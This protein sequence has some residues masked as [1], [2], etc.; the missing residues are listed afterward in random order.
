MVSS[1]CRRHSP[2]EE[3]AS[4]FSNVSGTSSHREEGGTGPS[5]LSAWCVCSHAAETEGVS[6]EYCCCR[7]VLTLKSSPW[8][9]PW[10]ETL[11]RCYWMQVR[12]ENTPNRSW[13]VDTRQY[14]D[15][16]H[17]KPA[18]TP[19]YASQKNHTPVDTQNTGKI[20][21]TSTCYAGLICVRPKMFFGVRVTRFRTMHL[22]TPPTQH[23]LRISLFSRRLRQ[24]IPKTFSH[25]SS[26]QTSLSRP[27]LLYI[28]VS[29]SFALIGLQYDR[30][31]LWSIRQTMSMFFACEIPIRLC[32]Y[33][34]TGRG[35][36]VSAGVLSMAAL[37]TGMWPFTF[38]APYFYWFGAPTAFI[39]GYLLL[40]CACT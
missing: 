7:G 19:L 31:I 28:A 27:L 39:L 8:K 30:N 32:M 26:R 11:Q 25:H 13:E 33:H 18:A 14:L 23:D 38:S 16:E 2:N 22:L 15:S 9:P 29:R 3:A 36:L 12:R 20:C 4:S 21:T 37:S 1:I 35:L 17:T 5:V 6:A 34:K 24:E 10:P 40:S